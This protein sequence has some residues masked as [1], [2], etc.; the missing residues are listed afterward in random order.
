MQKLFENWREYEKEVLKEIS[1][2]GGAHEERVLDAIASLRIPANADQIETIRILISFVDPTQISAWPDIPPAID[3]WEADPSIINTGLLFLALM[4]VIPIVGKGAKLG[5]TGLKLALKNM[6]TD[7]L[8]AV[9]SSKAD[10]GDMLKYV[11]GQTKKVD[12]SIKSQVI[13]SVN[14][15]RR[16]L[17]PKNPRYRVFKELSKEGRRAGQSPWKKGVYGYINP[18]VALKNL[19]LVKVKPPQVVYHGGA[20]GIDIKNLSVASR[21]TRGRLGQAG[22]YTTAD[23]VSAGFFKQSRAGSK[24]EM[25]RIEIDPSANV[26]QLPDKLRRGGAGLEHLKAED[27][28]ELF[29][30]GVQALWDPVGKDLV[31]LDKSI[32]MNVVP[33]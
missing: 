27:Q 23:T 22:F 2:A 7:A 14:W 17:D 6:K 13:Q 15:S 16:Y 9:K 19:R 10:V 25:Y 32:I 5:K 33:I 30:Q 4:A 8:M 3:A 11:S 20:K 31:I 28:K 29:D 26:Y 12:L 21:P 24:G 18:D 1:G